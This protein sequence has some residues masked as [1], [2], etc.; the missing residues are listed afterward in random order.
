MTIK[1]IISFGELLLNLNLNKTKQ[2]LIENRQNQHEKQKFLK[3]V[4][5]TC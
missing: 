5:I 3:N 2:F 4:K 1:I